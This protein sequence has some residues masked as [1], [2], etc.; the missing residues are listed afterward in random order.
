MRPVFKI[1]IV[2]EILF[3]YFG[4]SYIIQIQELK[5]GLKQKS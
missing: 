2:Y 4:I 1:I 3:F 5:I